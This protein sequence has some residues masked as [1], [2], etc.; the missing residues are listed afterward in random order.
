MHHAHRAAVRPSS[1]ARTAIAAPLLLLALMTPAAAQDSASLR[2]EIDALKQQ[3]QRMEQR[4]Q[5]AEALAAA[6]PAPASASAFNPAI[7]LVLDG[8]FGAA[9]RNPAGSRV[10]GFALGDEAGAPRR[11]FALGESELNF[12]ANVDQWLYGSLT[13]AF[14]EEGTVGVEE[15]FAHERLGHSKARRSH[16]AAQR[17]ARVAN[18]LIENAQRVRIDYRLAGLVRGTAKHRKNLGPHAHA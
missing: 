11:G 1:F 4:L 9:S 6:K 3:L 18:F 8:R 12:S 16:E 2:Q 5:G 17:V 13:L 10:P 7:G 14:E 15:A